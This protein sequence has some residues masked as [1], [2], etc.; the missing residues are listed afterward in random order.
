MVF[1]LLFGF[2]WFSLWLVAASC[3]G[4][5]IWVGSFVCLFL[6]ACLFGFVVCCLLRFALL[7]VGSVFGFCIG[8][9]WCLWM[10]VALC[11]VSVLVWVLFHGCL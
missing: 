4:F 9:V 11:G 7:V 2:N 1:D 3:F 10:L 5:L 8:L 6:L